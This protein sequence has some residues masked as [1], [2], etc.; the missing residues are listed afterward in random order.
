MVPI[1]LKAPLKKE[2]DRLSNIGVIQR[3][4]TPTDWISAIVVTTKKNG[5]VRLCIDPEPLN[6]APHRN[7]R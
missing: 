6:Q 7:H 4:D 2:L 3:V 1:A 5:K